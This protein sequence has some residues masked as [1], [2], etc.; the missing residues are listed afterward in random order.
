MEASAYK[1]IQYRMAPSFNKYCEKGWWRVFDNI[2]FESLNG[3]YASYETQEEEYN[4][5]LFCVFKNGTN[6]K[7]VIGKYILNS[8]IRFAEGN[9]EIRDMRW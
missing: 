5:G 7:K 1:L 2:K 6:K 8:K 3:E 4:M 9:E